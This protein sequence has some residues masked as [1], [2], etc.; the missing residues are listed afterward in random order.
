MNQDSLVDNLV[1]LDLLGDSV[2][3]SYD[4]FVENS[5]EIHKRMI[6]T[7]QMN[8][9]EMFIVTGIIWKVMTL[10]LDVIYVMANSLTQKIRNTIMKIVTIL[11]KHIHVKNVRKLFWRILV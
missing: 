5:I 10:T 11:L 2:D 7:L 3:V 4:G 9:S 6:G 1:K 8:V